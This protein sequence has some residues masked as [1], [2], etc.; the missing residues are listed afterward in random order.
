M[1]KLTKAVAADQQ[2]AQGWMFFV[3]AE[4]VLSHWSRK[5]ADVQRLVQHRFNVLPAVLNRGQVQGCASAQGRP[6]LPS[7]CIE[8]E[9]GQA[10]RMTACLH[11]ERTAMPVNQIG[12]RTMLHHHALRLTGGARRVDHV[13]Q[14]VTAQPRY[15][16][17]VVSPWPS[18]QWSNSISGIASGGRRSISV[19][20][21]NTTTGALSLSR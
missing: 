5:E 17:I 16:R 4:G 20:S 15:L 7:H 6:D 12:Q 18:A 9:S 10:G 19:D 14:I 3:L 8:A 11:I 1:N 21:V 2:S 13:N